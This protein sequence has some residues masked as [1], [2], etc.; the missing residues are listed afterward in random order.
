M[1]IQNTVLLV[2]LFLQRLTKYKSLHVEHVRRHI[3]SLENSLENRWGIIS[4]HLPEN[5]WLYRDFS[6]A[7]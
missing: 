4:G 2:K 6:P 7:D 3:L 1:S 5:F